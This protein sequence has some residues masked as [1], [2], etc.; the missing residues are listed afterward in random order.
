MTDGFCPGCGRAAPLREY[1]E[2]ARAQRGLLVLD[3]T[4]AIGVLGRPS[5]G[6]G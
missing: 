4:Q 5:A 3:D 1:L 6:A 2:S